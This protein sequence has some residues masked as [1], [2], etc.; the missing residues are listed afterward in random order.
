MSIPG[1]EDVK[2]LHIDPTVAVDVI[3]AGGTGHATP[4]TSFLGGPVIP[5][6]SF[7]GG[8]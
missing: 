6:P 8:F 2:V 4:L 5:L 1:H 7:L 3:R